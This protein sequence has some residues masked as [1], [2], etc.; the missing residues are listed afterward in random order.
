[1]FSPSFLSAAARW[2]V[3]TFS[4]AF[5]LACQG[6]KN[7]EPTTGNVEKPAYARLF[8]TRKTPQGVL[9]TTYQPADTSKILK[10]YL[11]YREGHQPDTIPPDVVPV[12]IPL[13]NVAVA[14][15]TQIGL[16]AALGCEQFI[17]SIGSRAALERNSVLAE[18]EDLGEFFNGWQFDTEKLLVLAPDAVFFSPGRTEDIT[19]L[20]K[21]IR[22]PMLYDLSPWENHPLARSEWLKFTAEFFDCRAQA[23]SLFAQIEQRYRDICQQAQ[24]SGTRPQVLSSLPYQGV[25]YMPAGESYKAVLFRDAALDFPWADTPQTGSLALDL[26]SVLARASQADV[27]F[28]ETGM[29]DSP[30]LKSLEEQNRLYTHFKA[31]RN[32]DIFICNSDHGAPYFEQSIVYP[33][34]VLSDFTYLPR[35]KDYRP[36]YYQ[37]IERQ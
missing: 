1:M 35:E 20:E 17:R 18:R 30:T 19:T 27:W 37:R 14:H 12:R 22:V 4:L 32:G 10:R 31:F 36:Y 5:T 9:V 34:R 16:I 26:E 8:D 11:L 24:T 33:D 13:E 3:L 21:G 25:W 6:H 2:A 29:G 7:T 23:D 15:S 28:F